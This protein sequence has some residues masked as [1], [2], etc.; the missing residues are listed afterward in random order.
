[1]LK[2]CSGSSAQGHL[3]PGPLS[4]DE[5][6]CGPVVVSVPRPTPP[7]HKSWACFHLLSLFHGHRTLVL[8]C[9]EKADVCIL[10]HWGGRGKQGGV[11]QGAAPRH[12]RLP[13]LG[14]SASA[15]V[16]RAL[17]QEAD[18][19]SP[20]R[21]APRARSL[22]Q[23]NISPSGTALPGTQ[24]TKGR[25]DFSSKLTTDHKWPV[26]PAAKALPLV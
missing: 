19:S 9:V 11:S 3:R 5:K 8:G 21:A 16:H 7:P 22:P 2:A 10:A 14:C 17:P 23:P 18:P 1:M 4:G 12:P 13:E 20:R 25:R 15:R 26:L 24:G 6:P